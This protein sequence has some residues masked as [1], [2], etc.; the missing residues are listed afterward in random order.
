[1]RKNLPMVRGESDLLFGSKVEVFRVGRI[2]EFTGERLS[3]AI[4]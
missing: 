1:M 2:G 4:F 3:C